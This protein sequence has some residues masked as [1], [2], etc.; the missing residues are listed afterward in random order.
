[1]LCGKPDP[2]L[3]L[4]VLEPAGDHPEEIWRRSDHRELQE[5]QS[6][7]RPQPASYSPRGPSSRLPSE[8]TGIFPRRFDLLVPPDYG[9]QGHRSSPH[10]LHSHRPLR[11]ARHAPGQKCFVRLVRRGD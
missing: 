4:S 10:V 11:V 6:D 7:Q 9:T 2:A 3:D 1:M 8:G 5:T